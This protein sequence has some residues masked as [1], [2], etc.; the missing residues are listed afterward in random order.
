MAAPEDER[1]NLEALLPSETVARYAWLDR[2][3]AI[4]DKSSV[5][6]LRIALVW[7]ENGHLLKRLVCGLA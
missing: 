2:A 1:F 7:T 4:H 5:D 6:A 3:G